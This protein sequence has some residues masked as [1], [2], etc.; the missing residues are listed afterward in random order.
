LQCGRCGSYRC[1]E[2]EEALQ[3]KVPYEHPQHNAQAYFWLQ[4]LSKTY[5]CLFGIIVKLFERSESPYVSKA[6]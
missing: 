5:L 6:W 3:A 4:Q 2:V 1:E